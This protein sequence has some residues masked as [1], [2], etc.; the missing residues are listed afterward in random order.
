MPTR[1]PEVQVSPTDTVQMVQSVVDVQGLQHHCHFPV[2]ATFKSNHDVVTENLGRGVV[3]SVELS[4][5]ATDH[6]I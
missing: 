5:L 2:E 6:E 4:V 1:S 3:D